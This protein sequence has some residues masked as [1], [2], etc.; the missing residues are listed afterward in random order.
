VVERLV[1][2]AAREMKLDPLAL[3]RRNFV[4]NDAY[5]YTTPVSLTYDSGDYF[6][7]LEMAVKAADY[8][9]FEQ[10]RQQ[11]AKRGKLRGIGICTYIEACA[12][13]PS[14]MAGQLG[15]RAGFYESA[16]VRAHPTGS[17]TVF[18][19]SHSHGQGHET[20]FAQ[21]VSDRFGVPLEMVDIVH[22]D[23]PSALRYGDVRVAL[24][25]GGR[26]RTGQGHGQDRRQSQEDRRP[27]AR[28]C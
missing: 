1:D 5:P 10:R 11:A 2:R 22:G 13:A 17:I 12:M 19:G 3:R 24:A 23:T 15:A 16:E 20:T 6:K 27:S 25:C 26:Y 4:P 8:A 9:G 28:S 7:T 21:L 14:V 18:T